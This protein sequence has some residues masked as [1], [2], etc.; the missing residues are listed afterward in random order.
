MFVCP[1]GS[2]WEL[3]PDPQV[4]RQEKKRLGLAW[5]FA[6]SKPTPSSTAPQWLPRPP[7]PSHPSPPGPPGGDQHAR[8]CACGGHSHSNCHV[9]YQHSSLSEICLWGFWVGVYH[10]RANREAILP[11]PS[12]TDLC[13]CVCPLSIHSAQISLPEYSFVKQ[14]TSVWF[15]WS[16]IWMFHIWMF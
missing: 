1:L 11:L 7:N 4:E 8:I 9:A 10:L 2:S 14:Y 3:H 13:V 16:H 15:W 5:G 6:I 12:R